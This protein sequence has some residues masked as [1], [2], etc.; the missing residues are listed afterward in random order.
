[1][2]LPHLLLALQRAVATSNADIRISARAQMAVAQERLH[3]ALEQVRPTL[4]RQSSL[5]SL[6]AFEV[7]LQRLQ[8]NGDEA[9]EL[10][11]KGSL[12]QALTL[13]NSKEFLALEQESDGLLIQIE[14][15]KEADIHDTAKNLAEYAQRS[16]TITYV[17]LL[18]TS[19][20]P[21]DG[22]LSRMPS[23]A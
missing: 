18:Y 6:L 3:E 8:K 4:R 11:G 1:M 22:L 23:S 5:N 16:S 14:K 21:R 15:N 10:A 17:C 7:V 2:Q 9:L 13:L 20:S 19:P 12:G